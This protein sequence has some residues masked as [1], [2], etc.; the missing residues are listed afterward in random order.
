MPA[1]KGAQL[2]ADDILNE[3]KEKAAG[4][5]EAAK[6]ESHTLLDAARF[7]AK[8][9]EER[10]TKE[11][12]ARGKHVYDGVLAEGRMRAKRELLQK[13]EELI[14]EVFRE[15]EKKL[16]VHA[17][18]EKYEKDIIRI[19]SMACKKL[20]VG[21]VVIR[22]NHRDLKL[23]EESKDQITR[24]LSENKKK[25]S[26]SFGEPIQTIGGVKVGTADGRVEIDETFEGRMRREFEDLRVKVAKV[27]FEGSR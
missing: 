3:A 14:N 23:L 22:A 19:A 4:I 8:E 2:I 24:E 27:L 18:S 6:K 17:S 10:K 1:E 26:V 16:Q 7:G 20:G 11:A 5:I 12:H 21:D 9:E 25:A 13:R 15:V